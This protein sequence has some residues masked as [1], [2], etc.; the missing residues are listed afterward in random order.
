ML[1]HKLIGPKGGK[2]VPLGPWIR[3]GHNVGTTCETKHWRI[4]GECDEWPS[5]LVIAGRT[6][7]L[8]VREEGATDEQCLVS[9][10]VRSKNG[11]KSHLSFL[12]HA[13]RQ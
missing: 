13:S 9:L 7:C 12:F 6:Y 8:I 1:G 2:D 5:M 4:H 11:S 3:R 10:H